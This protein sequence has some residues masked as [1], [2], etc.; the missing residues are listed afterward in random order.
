VSDTRSPEVRAADDAL[1]EA[2]QNRA[3]LQGDADDRAEAAG[4]VVTDFIVVA[5]LNSFD[6]SDRSASRYCYLTIDSGE[7]PLSKPEHC[8]RGLLDRAKHWLDTDHE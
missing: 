6:L 7:G 1:L 5:N 8:V 2:I 3:R 4:E